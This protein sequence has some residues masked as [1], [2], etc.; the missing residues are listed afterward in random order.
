MP[1]QQLVYSYAVTALLRPGYGG[2]NLRTFEQVQAE[3]L[4][5][6]SD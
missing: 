6:S 4:I 1:H 3:R 2:P 5:A